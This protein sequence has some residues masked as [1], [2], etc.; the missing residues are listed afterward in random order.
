MFGFR[1]CGRQQERGRGEGG[2]RARLAGP[3][4]A[5]LPP[6]PSRAGSPGPNIPPGGFHHTPLLPLRLYHAAARSPPAPSPATSPPRPATFAPRCSATRS[7]LGSG[8]SSLDHSRHIATYRPTRLP[9]PGHPAPRTTCFRRVRFKLYFGRG[10]TSAGGILFRK[11]SCRI[12]HSRNITSFVY[13][14]GDH[15]T[16]RQ[17]LSFAIICIYLIAFRPFK[18]RVG[19]PGTPHP[20]AAAFKFSKFFTN[21][22]K[23]RIAILVTFRSRRRMCRSKRYKSFRNHNSNRRKKLFQRPKTK[24][25][26]KFNRFKSEYLF[27]YDSM[28]F[29]GVSKAIFDSIHQHGYRTHGKT[30]IKGNTPVHRYPIYKCCA[31]GYT[32]QQRQ[33][34]MSQ[35]PSILPH[36]PNSKYTPTLYLFA[37]LSKRNL[38][39]AP[40]QRKRPFNKSALETPVS[41]DYTLLRSWPSSP[42]PSL[43]HTS[44]TVCHE[45]S[46]QPHDSSWEEDQ[47]SPEIFCKEYKSGKSCFYTY[48]GT[49]TKYSLITA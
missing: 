34:N 25:R 33:C 8:I 48:S 45:D 18:H 19:T 2:L 46:S 42:T 7:R 39:S 44:S 17:K 9:D 12:F 24:C 27:K 11:P 41:T 10:H 21:R 47:S 20:R 6:S 31:A 30:C 13:P 49:L 15:S 1:G 3:P 5:A 32:T 29:R 26:I 37:F 16:S 28:Q 40:A 36:F 43:S 35:Y 4:W 38:Q 23:P 22:H 14:F